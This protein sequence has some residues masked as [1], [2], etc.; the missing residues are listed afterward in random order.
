MISNLSVFLRV[1]NIS[2]S[3]IHIIYKRVNEYNSVSSRLRMI[4]KIVNET[5]KRRDN[6]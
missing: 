5:D 1:E 4:S 3:K 2:D 6:K